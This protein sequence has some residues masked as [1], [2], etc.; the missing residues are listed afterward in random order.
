M[1]N[2]QPG[3]PIDSEEFKRVEAYKVKFITDKLELSPE[4][5]QAF[6]P[7]YNE[8]SKQLK[9]IHARRHNGLSRRDIKQQW[10]DLDDET[11][12]NIALQELQNQADIANL[13]KEYFT[14]FEAV[15]GSRKAATFYRIELEFHRHLMEMLGKGRKRR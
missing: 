5:A 14:K 10:D 15:L 2:A 1:I 12:K 9:E 13:K 7:V 6:W 4:E 3:P 11:L 8:Y